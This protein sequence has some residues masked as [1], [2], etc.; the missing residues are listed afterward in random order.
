MGALIT[1]K[2]RYMKGK[3]PEKYWIEDMWPK[4]EELFEKWHIDRN[5]G[6][7]L[8]LAFCAMDAD[9]GGTVDLEECF[10]YLGGA[11]TKFTE[12]VWYA[13]PKIND[14]GEFEEGLNFEEFAVVCWNYCTIAPTHMAKLVFEIYDVEA[15]GHLEKPDIESLYCMLYD[16]DEHDEYYVNELPFSADDSITKTAFSTY[17]GKNRHIIQPCL[18]Y[19]NRLRRKF[20]GYILWETLAGHRKRQFLV[21]DEKSA[22]ME[23]ALTAIVKSEDPN[24]KMRKMEAD[25]AMAEAKAVAEAEAAAAA[26][27][28]RALDRAKEEE[29]RREELSSE[30]RFM[31]LHWMALDTL[32]E[33]FEH[34]EF[35]VD[36]AYRRHEDKQDLYDTLDRY[37]VSSDEYWEVKDQAELVLQIGTD[38]D[39]KAR[40]TDLIKTPEGRQVREFTIYKHALKAKA[41]VLEGVRK[42]KT[43]HGIVPARTSVE[44]EI[45]LNLGEIEK[46]KQ[47]IIQNRILI[48]QG[49]LKSKVK[50]ALIRPV[51]FYDEKK[52]CNKVCSKVE[53]KAAE[54]LAR[55]EIYEETKAK[56][57]ASAEA[58][59]KKRKDERDLDLKRVE[60]ELASTYGSRIT[61]WEYC[62]DRPNEKYVY[63]NLDTL[64][65]IHQKTAICEM[66]D[67]IF[68]QSDKKCKGCD[69]FR[70][71]KNQML[72]RPLGYKDI[73][74]D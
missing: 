10:A 39:H 59:I 45:D 49:A 17:V 1:K 53:M 47:R 35:L 48:S 70:S 37:K 28:L 50:A 58:F 68:D 65:V 51:D 74:I 57:I 73:R 43:S 60:F 71:A 20:G 12:R 72:Y 44:N 4:I 69:S 36:D 9:A 25:R 2:Q 55:A 24:R 26:E 52:L 32:R 11:R 14:D 23:E 6:L 33:K 34:T 63:V 41:A 46:K 16:C 15:V 56:A 22:S 62:W 29:A 3:V 19:Q 31:K 5:K 61:R 8:F 18:D 38:D 54:E 27:E 67:S 7:D 66:C 13:A 64:E 30:N 21:Y 42:A 40:Y